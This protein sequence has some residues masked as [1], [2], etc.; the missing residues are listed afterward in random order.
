M[1]CTKGVLELAELNQATL[2]FRGLRRKEASSS[3]QAYDVRGSCTL[4]FEVHRE[5]E[6]QQDKGLRKIIPRK[7]I[8]IAYTRV[9]AD[10]R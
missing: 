4:W 6:L 3:L 7:F 5:G 2:N 8:D 10:D 1:Y 9:V